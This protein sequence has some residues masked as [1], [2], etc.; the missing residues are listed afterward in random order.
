MRHGFLFASCVLLAVAAPV[1]EAGAQDR[2]ES[3][4]RAIRRLPADSFPGL[5]E[6]V[7]EEMRRLGCLVPQG[8]DLEHPH[9]VV[10]GRFASVDQ[11][12]WAFLCST[13]GVSSIRV[14]W[15]GSE[16]CETPVAAAEDRLHLQGLGGDSI[17][18]SR[19]LIPVG[20][21][22][23][24]GYAA[25]FGSGPVPGV[26]YQGIEDYFE[27]KASSVLLCIDGEWLELGGMD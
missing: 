2:W 4:E 13:D 12:D 18:F 17:G 14:L 1:H 10:A 15:G 25:A 20:R 5:P 24:M 27:G 8:S 22:R 23:M 21:D 6:R 11:T 26:W 9:N 7:A 3:A 19:R 16:R